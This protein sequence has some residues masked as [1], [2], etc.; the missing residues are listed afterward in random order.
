MRPISWDRSQ[1]SEEDPKDGN[2]IG[3]LLAEPEQR[4]VG[5]KGVCPRV[6]DT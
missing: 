1:G 4:G 5:A 6:T 2:K 3:G